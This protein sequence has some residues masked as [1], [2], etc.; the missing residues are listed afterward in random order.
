VSVGGGVRRV[1]DRIF[2]YGALRAIDA[3]TGERKWELKYTTPSLAGVMSTA[4]GLV[5]AGDNEGNFNAVD[6]K[7]GKPLWHYPTGVAIWGAAA[8]TFMLDGKQYVL[9]PSGTTLV[10]FSL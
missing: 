5:F 4:S 8:T 7:T 9:I 6:A 3:S 2:D 1:S 10:A